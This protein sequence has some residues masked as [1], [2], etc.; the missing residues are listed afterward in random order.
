MVKIDSCCES[1]GYF[2]CKLLVAVYIVQFFLALFN[3]PALGF[4]Q[5]YD[6]MF[7][8][9]YPVFTLP[10]LLML[11]VIMGCL[12]DKTRFRYFGGVMLFLLIGHDLT[13][14][15]LYV[16][17]LSRN[18]IDHEHY[19]D[20]AKYFLKCGYKPCQI[21]NGTA[22][23]YYFNASEECNPR[24]TYP[25]KY[26]TSNRPSCK[27]QEVISCCYYDRNVAEYNTSL[28][29]CIMFGLTGTSLILLSLW[30][31]VLKTCNKCEESNRKADRSGYYTTSMN[32]DF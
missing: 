24:G 12:E 26:G 21:A 30:Y 17:V 1:L 22:D 14:F 19:F 10:L 11:L 8:I 27:P 23:D 20:Y 28:T 9:W 15:G 3:N 18:Q 25:S 5:A 32:S 4:Y 31:L 6:P 29:S 7:F 2:G 16:D 13:F